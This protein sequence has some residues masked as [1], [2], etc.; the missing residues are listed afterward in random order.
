V[1]AGSDA[2]GRR[3]EEPPETVADEEQPIRGIEQAEAVGQAVQGPDDPCRAEP[4]SPAGP[5]LPLA[6]Q[7]PSIAP[8]QPR[9]SLA[10]SR[11]HDGPP[12]PPGAHPPRGR[13]LNPAGN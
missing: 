3:A 13:R 8:R 5:I 9:R 10:C 11:R 1:Q 6:Q 4:P 12:H 2:S 7:R